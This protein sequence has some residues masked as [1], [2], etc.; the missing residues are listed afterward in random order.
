[1]KCTES[2]NT[3]CNYVNFFSLLLL[4]CFFCG[5]AAAC[6]HCVYVFRCNVPQWRPFFFNVIHYSLR[7]N[8]IFP[9]STV[10]IMQFLL[11]AYIFM[12][13]IGI[14]NSFRINFFIF[15]FSNCYFLLITF[16]GLMKIISRLCSPFVQCIQLLN[17]VD[18]FCLD[19]Y[20]QTL[21]FK[22][23]KHF[24]CVFLWTN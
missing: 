11:S 16:F 3:L 5:A 6:V 24:E 17:R 10:L 2:H 23:R 18:F 12:Q 20:I 9:S 19:N 8:F 15:L 13:I 1:M 21:N 22:D 4:A 14:I 7:C